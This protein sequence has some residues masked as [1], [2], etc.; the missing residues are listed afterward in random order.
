MV[1]LTTKNLPSIIDNYLCKYDL[2][3]TGQEIKELLEKYNIDSEKFY[4][5]L[6]VNTCAIID[7]KTITYH[8]DIEKGLRCVL[9]DRQQNINEWD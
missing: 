3:F 9:E 4:V 2:G 1:K 5:A 8:C 7:G 6:G